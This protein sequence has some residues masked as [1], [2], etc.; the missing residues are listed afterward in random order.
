MAHSREPSSII[1]MS[2]PEKNC[3]IEYNKGQW[4]FLKMQPETRDY[5][6]PV[7]SNSKF[8]LKSFHIYYTENI[9][10]LLKRIEKY[11]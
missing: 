7:I 10:Y 5:N 3:Y 11:E 8:L 2:F 9:L 4:P 1:F 6:F